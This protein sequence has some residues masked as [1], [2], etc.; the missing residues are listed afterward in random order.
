MLQFIL[1]I[2]SFFYLDVIP[3]KVGTNK[4]N[5][6]LMGHS[7]VLSLHFILLEFAFLFHN[8]NLI[9]C[10]EKKIFKKGISM[11]PLAGLALLTLLVILICSC[12]SND[13]QLQDKWWANKQH[14][15]III[16]F[17]SDGKF[18]I[19][20]CSD[21][22]LYNMNKAEVNVRLGDYNDKFLV[23][24]INDRELKITGYE[25]GKEAYY[26][27]AGDSDF[28]VGEWEGMKDG[29]ISEY[30]FSQFRELTTVIDSNEQ[31]SVYSLKNGKVIIN[32]EPYNLV[33]SNDKCY[34]T[35]TGKNMLKLARLR[36]PFRRM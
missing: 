5:V 13:K 29:K 31:K 35:L 18:I 16:R 19:L 12:S 2:C 4:K 30:I 6:S 15:D 9:N 22:L 21:E 8:F 28:I 17:A 20:N 27:I 33:F 24:K 32:N 23:N 25:P 14:K 7:S 34:L 3:A 26:K 1:L 36:L 11:K 10:S